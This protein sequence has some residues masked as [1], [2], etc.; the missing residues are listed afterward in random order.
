[1]STL[2][3][4]KSTTGP[5]KCTRSSQR[6]LLS[7]P[8]KCRIPTLSKS[9]RLCKPT[10]QLSLNLLQASAKKKA[11]RLLSTLKRSLISLLKTSLKGIFVLDRSQASP[12][13]LKT[14]VNRT[15]LGVKER[16]TKMKMTNLISWRPLRCRQSGMSRKKPRG[17][18]RRKLPRRPQR[19]KPQKRK[20]LNEYY[21]TNY[22]RQLLILGKRSG[23][24]HCWAK[25]WLHGLKNSFKFWNL[26]QPYANGDP[27]FLGH[28]FM[29]VI[30]I[31]LKCSQDDRFFE[32]R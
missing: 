26:V 22:K 20:R 1:V 27:Y 19:W 2:S 24:F 23:I 9:L 25:I 17:R 6:L 10:L 21:Y 4:T 3:T 31:Q 32:A 7:Q 18:L 29:Y 14:A 12:T 11:K 28:I 16:E 30:F 13:K 15:S 5:R 8:F